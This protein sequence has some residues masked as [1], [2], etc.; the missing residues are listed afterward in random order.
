M[1]LSIVIPAY[2]ENH[3]IADDVRVAAEFLVREGLQGEILVVDDGSPDETANLA[4]SVAVPEQVERKVIRYEPNRGKGFAIRTGMRQSRG[5][6]VMFADSGNCVPYHYALSGLEFLQNGACELA[7]GSRKLPQSIIKR[8]HHWYRMLF[9]KIFRRLAWSFMGIPHSITD[10]QCGFK[11]YR[12]DVGRE[13]YAECKSEHFM[14]DA[15]I[16]LRALAKG[17]QIREFPVEWNSD[18]DSRFRFFRASFQS[19]YDLMKV[20]IMLNREKKQALKA[21]RAEAKT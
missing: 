13:L 4:E 12:G 3:K 2:R 10:S 17:Y 5:Q 8:K 20:K 21:A 11:M 19:L 18:P 14:F 9:S 6:Y 7:H 1:D 15:E 16:I